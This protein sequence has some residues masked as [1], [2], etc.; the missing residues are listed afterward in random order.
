M[1][2]KMKN[3]RG[4]QAPAPVLEMMADRGQAGAPVLHPPLGARLVA[5]N[6]CEFRVWAPARDRIELHIVAPNDRRVPMRKNAFGYHETT[7][8]VASGTRYF[9]TVDGHD[10]PDPASRYQ[11]DGVHGPSAVIES[12]FEWHDKE[13]KGIALDDYVIDEL[14][15]GTFT[16]EG[17]FDAIIPK[18]DAL[19]EL[20]ITAIELLPI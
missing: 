13:W 17:T 20:G 15:V 9:F 2:R 19:K 12:A 11:P 18:L 4:G 10:R 7:I 1:N 14:H 5:P 3:E 6:R 16:T 8:D